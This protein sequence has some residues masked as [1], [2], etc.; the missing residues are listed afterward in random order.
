M[1]EEFEIVDFD[2]DAEV[3]QMTSD[4]PNNI[5]PE[6]FEE[7]RAFFLNDE[8]WILA[9]HATMTDVKIANY[10]IHSTRNDGPHA[11]FLAGRISGMC[12]DFN[13]RRYNKPDI[14]VEQFVAVVTTIRQ[15]ALRKLGEELPSKPCLSDIS[16]AAE[17]DFYQ[18]LYA[19]A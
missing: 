6:T 19:D 5:D 1:A 4:N 2:E 11:P 10:P 18:T 14:S 17:H 16:D 13:G 3:L 9:E 7:I 8:F 12:N 15:E